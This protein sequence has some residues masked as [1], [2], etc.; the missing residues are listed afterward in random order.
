M[1]Y[2]YS[3]GQLF[4]DSLS[5]IALKSCWTPDPR[6][7]RAACYP[8]GSRIRLIENREDLASRYFTYHVVDHLNCTVS[9]A[10]RDTW[11]VCVY[12]K[13][14]RQQVSRSHATCSSYDAYAPSMQQTSEG[15]PRHAKQTIILQTNEQANEQ[16]R[17]ADLSG[18]GSLFHWLYQVLV[19]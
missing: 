7:I 15:R 4:E 12:D 8:K 19:L 18:G 11:Y 6:N 5:D 14:V 3:C 10:S 9:N 17:Q 2:L 1:V 16:T 13:D